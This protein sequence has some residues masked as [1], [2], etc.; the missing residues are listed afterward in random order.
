M[1]DSLFGKDMSVKTE[2][3]F[4]GQV[5]YWE[6]TVVSHNTSLSPYTYDFY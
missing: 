1:C 5:T 2:F 6:D 4:G 3:G